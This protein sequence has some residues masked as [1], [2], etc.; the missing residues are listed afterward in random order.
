MAYSPPGVY[1]EV[2]IANNI[3]SLPGGTRVLA[4]IGTGRRTKDVT[5]ENVFQPTAR[6][7]TLINADINSINSVYDFTGP[8][9][10]QKTYLASGNTTY[11]GAGYWLSGTNTI[12][13]TPAENEYPLSTTPPLTPVASANY[14]GTFDYSGTSLSGTTLLPISEES[15]DYDSTLSGTSTGTTLKLGDGVTILNVYDGTNTATA[16][17]YSG[18]GTGAGTS[19]WYQPI[20]TSDLVWTNGTLIDYADAVASGSIPA[21]GAAYYVDYEYSGTVSS[22]LYVQTGAYSNTLLSATLASGM[23]TVNALT[24]V[25]G[26][27]VSYPGSG[28]AAATGVDT[29]GYSKDGSGWTLSGSINDYDIT[30]S[31]VDPLTYAYPS[32]A[33]PSIS[34]S[35][36]VDYTYNK[37]S[38]DYVPLNFT[39]YT[40]IVNEYGPEGEWTLISTGSQ[41]GTY[42][43]DKINPLT[44]GA[45]IAFANGASVVT[46]CQMSGVGNTSGD[47][48]NS[49]NQ[50][51]SKIVDVIVPL[52]IGSGV[53]SN[54][55]SLTE[56]SLTQQ[57]VKLHCDSMSLPQNKKE[58]VG[59]G[60]LGAAEIGDTVTPLTYLFEANS[61]KDKR[62]NLVAPGLTTVQIQDKAGLYRN[63]IVDGSFLAV[64]AGA[65][66]CNP[67]SDVATPLT[68]KQFSGFTKII[69]T[70]TDHPDQ[71]YLESEKNILAA[72]GCMVIDSNGSRIFV[73]H[74]LT[75]DQTNQANGEFSVVTTTD[76]VSQAVRFT[77]E[78][79]IGKKLLTLIV[80]PA[81]QS[82]ILATMQAL[83]G[84]AII[85]AIGAITVDTNPSDPT[86]VLA[87]VQYVPVFPLNRIRVTFTIR[88]QI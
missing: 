78:S 44:L 56:I 60:S 48:Q 61:L 51:Q 69:S 86:E 35:Y 43:L 12:A 7:N 64:A 40:Q 81:I 84:E 57:N 22:Q 72:G 79:F 85:N 29:L 71:E 67:L 17:L 20:G 6:F 25:T 42:Q 33:V 55:M 59:L 32:S 54:D 83:A 53:T 18:T 58:R 3:V 2:E 76:Y 10:S 65:V 11:F 36:T 38:T 19:G 15:V 73:R 39:N 21:S 74:Q 26:N 68:N 8:G 14:Y 87:T 4:L 66:S 31:P 63:V 27:G 24:S 37:T 9:G 1:T 77:T 30:W 52:T 50:L 5:G 23:T 28:T 41:A 88:T 62:A 49:L 46:L 80:L 45:R 16:A 34:G 13:W 70:T 75:T 82:T 47:F